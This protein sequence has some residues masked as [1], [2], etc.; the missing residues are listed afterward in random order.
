MFSSLI[1][2]KYY[3]ETRDITGDR[4]TW[5]DRRKKREA[6]SEVHDIKVLNLRRKRDEK[7]FVTGKHCLR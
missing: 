2:I 6:G 7:C 3:N 5:E 4:H 1:I